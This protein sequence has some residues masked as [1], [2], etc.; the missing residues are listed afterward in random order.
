M[1]LA[2]RC[3][4][5]KTTF[6]VANDQLKLR[7]GLVR[8]GACKE[9]FN[10]IEHLLRADAA[11]QPT[12]AP[13][14]PASASAPSQPTPQTPP[15]SQPDT[16]PKQETPDIATFLKAQPDALR[17]E[18]GPSQPTAPEQ[19]KPASPPPPHYTYNSAENDPLQRMT[20]VDFSYDDDDT[21]E[22]SGPIQ[23][24]PRLQPDPNQPDPLEEAIE[25]LQRKPL[26]GS[27][28]GRR[29]NRGVAPDAEDG[30]VEEP[31]FVKQARRRERL[32]GMLRPLMGVGSIVLLVLLVA[33]GAFT[34]RS[35]LAVRFPGTKPVLDRACAL[36]HCEVG[37]PTQI[38]SVSIE[39]S[40]LQTVA[41]EKNTF[42]LTLLLR[43]HSATAQAWPNI[44]LTLNDAN[45]QPIARRVFV[46]QEYLGARPEAGGFGAKSEQAFKLFFEL[47]QVKASGYRVYLFYP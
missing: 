3:P 39:S 37:L 42:S 45:E 36:L 12:P 44:E 35:Q 2:T 33:Q 7:A 29:K 23:P 47:S 43:N 14:S 38:E 15:A 19:S 11:E 28:K 21:T 24:K 8:C 1:A 26:R 40:E 31:S 5:C 34:F 20:L 16:V 4:H 13:A 32:S 30:E 46:P 25:A 17:E 18:E 41:P 22:A 9:I 10:G 27:K 6:R